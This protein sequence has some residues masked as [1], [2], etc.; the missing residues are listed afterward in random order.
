MVH[1]ILKN[2]QAWPGTMSIILIETIL[3]MNEG[4]LSRTI[5]SFYCALGKKIFFFSIFMVN[6]YHHK[7]KFNTR[8]LCVETSWHSDHPLQA[9]NQPDTPD[10]TNI[11]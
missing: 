11:L 2:S 4:Y 9:S 8:Q 7:S 3:S 1:I 6:Y 10:T 5:T